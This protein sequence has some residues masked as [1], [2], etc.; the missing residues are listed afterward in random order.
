MELSC[1]ALQ[2]DHS[3]LR[4]LEAMVR[5]Y[6]PF[7]QSAVTSVERE[8]IRWAVGM[9]FNF[10]QDTSKL[11]R[12]ALILQTELI[13]CAIQNL[14][15]TIRPITKWTVE[16]LEEFTLSLLCHLAKIEMGRIALSKMGALGAIEPIIGK[17]GIHDH[18][19]G[20]IRCA[21]VGGEEG[22]GNETYAGIGKSDTMAEF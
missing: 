20:I 7:L 22:G 19:A 13:P 17:G 9:L 1:P 16:S 21:L 5:T 11:Q 6:S 18:R 2:N 8:T 15:R 12:I 14:K 10:C 4:V 3:L